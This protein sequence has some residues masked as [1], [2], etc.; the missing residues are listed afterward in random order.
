MLYIHSFGHAHPDTEI[1]NDFL[2]SLYDSVTANQLVNRFGISCR[3]SVLPLDYIRETLNKDPRLAPRVASHTPTSLGAAAAQMAIERAGISA[4]D[5]NL[6]MANCCTPLQTLPAEAQR[7]AGEMGIQCQAFDVFSASAGFALHLDYLRALRPERVPKFTLCVSTATLTTVVNY[8]NH[9]DAAIWGDGA[10][11]WI[12]SSERPA[13]GLRIMYTC[14]G[15]DPRRWNTVVVERLGHFHQNGIAVGHY[16]IGQTVKLL[17]CLQD[18]FGFSWKDTYFIG[19]Q[20]NGRMLDTVCRN[21]G[22]PPERHL[23]NVANIGNQAGAGAPATL[24]MKWDQIAAGAR[25]VVA[26][27][28]AGLSWGSVLLESLD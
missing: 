8:N 14:Y 2:E 10:A 5:I 16:S 28:G 25:L 4:R 24:S 27:V 18:S 9:I 22:I 3:R 21:E 26:V 6:V 17:R 19:H 11:A 1:T 12:V 13:R 23:S 20:A 15:T 7:I